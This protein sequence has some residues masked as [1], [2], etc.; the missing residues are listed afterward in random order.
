MRHDDLTTPATVRD[1]L[2]RPEP[3]LKGR[4]IAS[5]AARIERGIGRRR[6][7]GPDAS[8]G[9]ALAQGAGTVDA[10]GRSPA[11]KE[12]AASCSRAAWC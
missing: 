7:G 1:M 11:C 10:E 12:S 6:Y 3:I 8:A 9:K 5:G 4:T 2:L